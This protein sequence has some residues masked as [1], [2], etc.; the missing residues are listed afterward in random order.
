MVD[1][2]HH[3]QGWDR[4]KAPWGIQSCNSYQEFCCFSFVSGYRGVRRGRPGSFYW[5]EADFR[6]WAKA[7]GKYR[8]NN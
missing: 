2:A 3:L 8:L 7:V 1:L 5:P 6:P 4:N